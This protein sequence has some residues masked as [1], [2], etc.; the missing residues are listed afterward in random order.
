M[1]VGVAVLGSGARVC[2]VWEVGLWRRP[3]LSDP[4]FLLISPT[5]WGLAKE[6]PAPLGHGRRGAFRGKCL[7][8]PAPD[9]QL[10]AAPTPVGGERLRRESPLAWPPAVITGA[11]VLW[12]LFT[13]FRPS[14]VLLKDKL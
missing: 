4:G 2:V 13:S 12:P 8:F 6:S 3:Y 14:E 10:A 7:L 5:A 9:W 11:E 1:G